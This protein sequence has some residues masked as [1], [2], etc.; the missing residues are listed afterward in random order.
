MDLTSFSNVII[1]CIINGHFFFEMENKLESIF[2]EHSTDSLNKKGCHGSGSFSKSSLNIL[3]SMRVKFQYVKN[4][5]NKIDDKLNII[6][7]NY[8]IMEIFKE[9][10]KNYPR[11][12][13]TRIY[14]NTKHLI[15]RNKDKFA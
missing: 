14:Y 2:N 4:Y 7:S 6:D 8:R 11:C 9:N 3:N 10:K 12:D 1:N 15:K 13:G 5:N